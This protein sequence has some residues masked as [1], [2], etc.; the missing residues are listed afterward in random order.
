SQPN[1]V[2]QVVSSTLVPGTYSRCAGTLNRV[3]PTRNE[4]APRSSRLPN[5]D[6]ESEAGRHSQ[7]TDPSGATSA[8]VWQL[9][10]NPYSAMGGNGDL[11][12]PTETSYS[13]GLLCMMPPSA[14][15][16]VAVT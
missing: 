15:M 1:G 6:G 4:P 7:S 8:P 9:D 3:G 12:R 13:P 10:R 16:V 2:C 11:A 14:K 5:T